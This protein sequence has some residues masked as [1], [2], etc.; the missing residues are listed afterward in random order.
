[1]QRKLQL[2]RFQFLS[3]HALGSSRLIIFCLPS[4]VCYIVSK[5]KRE[6]LIVSKLKREKLITDNFNFLPSIAHLCRNR[7]V[8]ALS[9]L[10]FLAKE[11]SQPDQ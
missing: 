9:F 3:D 8:L 10:S 4:I 7:A 5:L 6:K 1:M 11:A 2:I